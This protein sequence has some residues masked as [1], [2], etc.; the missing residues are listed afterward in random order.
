[1][2]TTK[3]TLRGIMMLAW[4]M[5]KNNGYTMSE[6]L[7]TAWRNAKAK[8]RMTQGAI[9]FAYLKV[10]GTLREAYGT[11]C[12]ELVPTRTDGTGRKQNNAVQVYFD[13]TRGAWRSFRKANL[14]N[15]NY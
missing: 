6:A 11:L 3:D 15:I 14:V 5:V 4:Q 9:H 13:L 10:D 2:K 8:A 7:T 1:M 12:A